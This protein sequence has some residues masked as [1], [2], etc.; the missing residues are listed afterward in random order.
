MPRLTWINKKS[1]PK[2]NYLAALFREYRRATGITSADMAEKLG[3]TPENAR[4]Q[5]NKAPAAWNIGQL[6]RYCD[7]LGIPYTDAFEAAVK[8]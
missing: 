4:C 7:I 3:C 5:M 6:I 8:K 1:P 2:V